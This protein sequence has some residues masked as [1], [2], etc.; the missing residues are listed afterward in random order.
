MYDF[1]YIRN[2]GDRDSD[3]G[4]DLGAG[5]GDWEKDEDEDAEN[6]GEGDIGDGSGTARKEEG[7][8][9]RYGEFVFLGL[10]I[11]FML[12]VFLLLFLLSLLGY[13]NIDSVGLKFYY[14]CYEKFVL[15]L[16]FSIDLKSFF[17]DIKDSF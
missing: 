12:L 5:A 6:D 14:F 10:G 9:G 7:D 16:L 13:I 11:L 15:V 8:W 2:R 3:R 4:S 17:V 1:L